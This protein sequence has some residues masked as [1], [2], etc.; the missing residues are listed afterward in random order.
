MPKLHPLPNIHQPPINT[1]H[2][3]NKPQKQ[4]KP[5]NEQRKSVRRQSVLRPRLQ[6]VC[7]S[8]TTTNPKCSL[9]HEDVHET[10]QEAQP[11]KGGLDEH[12]LLVAQSLA[13]GG[14]R[15]GHQ[16]QENTEADDSEDHAGFTWP[17][18]CVC[19]FVVLG[20]HEERELRVISGQA[21]SRH[22]SV[23]HNEP[24]CCKAELLPQVHPLTQQGWERH[25]GGTP[26][27]LNDSGQDS[28][29]VGE[30]E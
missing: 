15:G 10:Q 26:I 5:R 4:H 18:H 21:D 22:E 28:G 27:Q 12:P 2:P 14:H 9:I 24:N 29:K 30:S 1:R 8:S 23:V 3:Q 7:T 11:S 19:S 17:S 20:M 6:P 13:N 25:F 16:N